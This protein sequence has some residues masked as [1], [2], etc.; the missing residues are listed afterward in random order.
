[1]NKKEQQKCDVLY[2]KHC[3][4]LRLQGKAKSTIENYSRALRRFMAFLD[5]S[6]DTATKADFQQ[7][8][9]ELLKTHSWSTIKCD[10]VGLQFF[11]TYVLEKEWDWV[12]IVKPP[13]VKS[14]PNVIT[15]AEVKR[16]LSKIKKMRYRIFFS[17][18]FYGLAHK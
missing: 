11:Y 4:C 13:T 16:L 9:K 3:N 12:K 15:E 2:E 8:F 14:I 7:Y 5:R 10:R 6:P 1:M 18:I 17:F